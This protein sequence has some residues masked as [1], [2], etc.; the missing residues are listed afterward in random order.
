MQSTLTLTIGLVILA[1]YL[2]FVII[3]DGKVPS[4]ISDTFYS[5][6]NIMFSVVMFA[7]SILLSMTLINLSPDS[8]T[9]IAFLT[10]AGLGIVGA[11]P[12]F[13]DSAQ[14]TS[15]Y[16]GAFMFGIGSQLWSA[17]FVSPFLLLIWLPVIPFLVCFRREATFTAE[18]GCVLV[19]SIAVFIAA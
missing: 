19:M 6:G 11:S 12:Y 1:A 18:M 7:E 15:H 5:S 10:G 14:K 2:T 8:Y 4:S 13:K 9:A 16:V 17:M 3:K